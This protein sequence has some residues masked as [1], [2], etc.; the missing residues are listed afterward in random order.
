[1]HNLSIFIINFTFSI[2]QNYEQKLINNTLLSL[3]GI[4]TI[5]QH[6]YYKI[7]EYILRNYQIQF[8]LFF[9]NEK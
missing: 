8:K 5:M 7:I 1:M 6:Y 2:L 4:Q 9:N 3:Y